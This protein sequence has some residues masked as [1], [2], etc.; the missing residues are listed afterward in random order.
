M[1]T[2]GAVAAGHSPLRLGVAGLGVAGLVLLPYVDAHPA[3]VVTAGADPRPE[4]R[5]AFA[6]GREV[7]LY[8]SVEALCASDAVDCV[9]LATPTH[10]HA[11]H[12]IAAAAGGKHGVVE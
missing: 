2:D 11:E 10:L 3:V 5:Q 1:A 4:A 8:D 12:A 6:A 7:A 9:Y